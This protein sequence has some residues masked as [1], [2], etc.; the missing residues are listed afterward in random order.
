MD[1][2]KL[3]VEA[4]DSAAAAVLKIKVEPMVVTDGRNSWFIGDG[5]CGF[6]WLEIRP[7]S[8]AGKNDCDFVKYLKS[9]RI[10]GYDDYSKSYN[11][12]VHDFGQCMQKKEAYAR[13]LAAVLKNSGIDV[14][15]KSRMD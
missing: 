7:A 13:G 14:R 8:K 12:W 2:K 15:V 4:Q 6:A 3:W 11:I 10:G 9:I 5:V 1:N